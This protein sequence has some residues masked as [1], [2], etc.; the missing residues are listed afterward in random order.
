MSEDVTP[1]ERQQR[2]AVVFWH[3]QVWDASVGLVG[4]FQVATGV[5]INLPLWRDLDDTRR[6]A[7]VTAADAATDVVVALVAQIGSTPPEQDTPFGRIILPP[8][9]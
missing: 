5:E 3:E 6:A 7:F 9:T 2:D 4:A 8:G 1:E